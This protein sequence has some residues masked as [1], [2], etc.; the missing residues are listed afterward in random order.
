MVG[1]VLDVAEVWFVTWR[2]ASSAVF[3]G[4]RT[5]CLYLS[6]APIRR[7]LRQLAARVAKEACC[8]SPL[9]FSGDKRGRLREIFANIVNCIPLLKILVLY[10]SVPDLNNG[11]TM[12]PE[13]DLQEHHASNQ[14]ALLCRIPRV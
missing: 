8:T 6:E 7:S 1:H 13:L 3:G 14:H 4:C 12:G 2:V 11:A 9:D 10:N 5:V